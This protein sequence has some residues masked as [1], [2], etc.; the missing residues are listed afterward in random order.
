MTQ[1]KN[2]PMTKTRTLPPVNVIL[3]NDNI[4]DASV[5]VQRIMEFVRLPQSDAEDRVLEAHTTGRSL[6]LSTHR[7]KAELVVEQFKSCHP[8]ITVEM[9]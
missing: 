7:E 6:I 9:E 5:V 2:R 3:H 1:T 8:P 4:N